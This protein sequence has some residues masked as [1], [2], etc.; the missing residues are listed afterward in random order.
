MLRQQR[1]SA[2][3]SSVRGSYGNLSL[4]ASLSF[5]AFLDDRGAATDTV[6]ELTVR[7]DLLD[8]SNAAKDEVWCPPFVFRTQFSPCIDL[9][10]WRR[11]RKSSSRSVARGFQSVP[12]LLGPRTSCR[13][14]RYARQSFYAFSK[15]TLAVQVVKETIELMRY[16]RTLMVANWETLDVEKIQH[17][18]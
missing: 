4:T 5:S 12:S 3:T 15:L 6:H 13:R 18:W 16:H 17:R 2:R 10:R 8:D 11:S 9:F 1:S 14:S 7:K